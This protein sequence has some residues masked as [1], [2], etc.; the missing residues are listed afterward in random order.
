MSNFFIDL[1]NFV[2]YYP[3][4]ITRKEVVMDKKEFD[5]TLA[6]RVFKKDLEKFK[7][8]SEKINKPYQILIREMIQAFNEDR[9][10][11][12]PTD[13]QKQSLETIYN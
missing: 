12:I 5:N 2:L 8:K 10:K 13:E 9:L 1:F 6:I 4:K 3:L 11:I 7:A